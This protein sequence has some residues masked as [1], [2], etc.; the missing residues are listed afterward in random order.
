LG[1]LISLVALLIFAGVF[2]AVW[3][4]F[5]SGDAFSTVVEQIEI[6]STSVPV[7]ELVAT[8]VPATPTPGVARE[9]LVFGGE[10]IGVGLLD[11]AREIALDAAGN[12][13]LADYSSGRVQRFDRSGTYQG[14]WTVVNDI[15]PVTQMTAARDGT[16]FVAQGFDIHR[17]E[18][19]TGTHLGTVSY[20]SENTLVLENVAPFPDGG[21]LI[22][23]R[24]T[25]LIWLDPAG[26][27]ARSLEVPGR[28]RGSQFERIA[29]DGQGNVFVLG[30]LGERGRLDDGVFR[31]DA[32]GQYHSFFGGSGDGAGQL[33]APDAIA[34]DGQGR[35]FVTD[36][37]GIQIFDPRGRY[38]AT[39]E[40]SGVPFGIAFDDQNHL[41]VTNRKQVFVYEL[42]DVE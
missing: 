18:G 28:E 41:W 6:L 29:V 14:Q 16:V 42:L 8:V 5:S 23:E 25:T 17:Y 32:N 4:A 19:T 9:L 24:G 38:L 10:G 37:N 3:G 22:N 12:V 1:L 7:Q 40:T 30:M 15:N 35:V 21:L 33:R 26:A 31:Y 20:P 2:W 13:Y 27:V 39:L 11:D 34:V 36:S